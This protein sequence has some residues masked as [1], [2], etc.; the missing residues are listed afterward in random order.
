ML[1]AQ[2]RNIDYIRIS[3]T[4]RCNLRCVYCMPETGIQCLTR[5]EILSYE[6]ILHVCRLLYTLGIRK[7]K[8]TG[9]EPLTRKGLAELVRMLKQDCRMESVTLTTNGILLT[10][11]LTE[12][13]RAGIDG[14]N[15][16]LDTLDRRR[17]M[18]IAR[19][20][21]FEHVLEGIRFALTFPQLNVKI[22]CVPRMDDPEDALAIA[23]LAK[24]HKLSIRFIEMMPIGLGRGSEGMREAELMQQIE[25]VYGKMTP[26]EQMMGN[27]PAHYYHIQG[28][29]GHIGF[30]SAISHK[31]CNT[32]NRIRLTADGYLKT[33]LQ[34]ESGVRLKE[35]LQSG[36]DDAQLLQYI[37]DAVMNKPTGHHFME[38]DG[39]TDLEQRHMSQ[40]GG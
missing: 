35:K 15:I 36:A 28:F 16:S 30:I 14:V 23:G 20:D 18:E 29:Q 17:F 38:E 8:L 31:F 11:Q 9:G 5:D 4:D 24:D 10:E 2:N 12:L 25:R 27:G 22:N 34:Y 13:V 33:C 7:V 3:V 19:R 40:I 37:R 1:D 39:E 21:K 32:C 26:F 6:E